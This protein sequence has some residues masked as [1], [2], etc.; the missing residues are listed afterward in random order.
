LGAD[1]SVGHA[2]FEERHMRR[3][4]PALRVAALVGLLPACASA[5]IL[6]GPGQA[7]LET[8]RSGT[9]TQWQN[10][11]SGTVE[12]IVPKPAFNSGGTVC[13]E[14]TKTVTIGGTQ[15]QAYGTACRQPDGTWKLAQQEQQPTE[16]RYVPQQ[17]APV[18]VAAPPP[19]VV[20]VY[21][22]P[23]YRPRPY[24]YEPYGWRP[25][26]PGPSFGFGYGFG[27]HRHHR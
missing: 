11:D 12:T 14:F 17:Q 20:Y 19:R 23:Y 24:Y 21:P 8:T 18:I 6:D 26:R 9:A 27:G 15:Q 4:G 22:E 7:A 5:Q 10:P 2:G 25:Y 16:Q 13:R 3:F 1:L